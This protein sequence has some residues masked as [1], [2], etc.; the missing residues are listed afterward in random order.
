V[1]LMACR[2]VVTWKMVPLCLMWCIWRERNNRNF[3][4][5]ERT[6]E[7]LKSYFFFS[8]FTRTFAYLAP[9]VISYSNFLTLFS[10]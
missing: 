1:E 2:S 3:D 7:E 10:P 8:L 4:N 6:L 5:L 9:L